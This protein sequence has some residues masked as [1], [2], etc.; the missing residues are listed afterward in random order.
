MV[1]SLWFLLSLHE[2]VFFEIVVN[3]KTV[4][5]NG[6]MDNG[7]GIF[8]I[9][10][11]KSNCETHQNKCDIFCDTSYDTRCLQLKVISLRYPTSENQHVYT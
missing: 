1:L 7:N 6:K 9:R 4:N 11:G 10:R 5:G 3:G 8:G 2:S